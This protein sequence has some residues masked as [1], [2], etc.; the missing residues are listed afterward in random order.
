[1]AST[2]ISLNEIGKIESS[3]RIRA[4]DRPK[5]PAIAQR[6]FSHTSARL[7][8][9]SG[10]RG[11]CPC[12]QKMLIEESIGVPF[13]PRI[14]LNRWTFRAWQGVWRSGPLVIINRVPSIPAQ[15]VDILTAGERCYK[16]KGKKVLLVSFCDRRVPPM[17]NA[18]LFS[19]HDG[20]ANLLSQKPLWCYCREALPSSPVGMV[21]ARENESKLKEPLEH[22]RG[23]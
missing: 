6:R 11:T 2:S 5:N 15:S 12:A 14:R 7:I 17:S 3:Q 8:R 9:T 4:A 21:D 16:M 13:L 19:C 20:S 18:Y 1:M 10:F 23:G 22:S